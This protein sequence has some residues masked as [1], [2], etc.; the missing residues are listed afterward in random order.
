[1]TMRINVIIQENIENSV[2][3]GSG[4]TSGIITDVERR[5]FNL[6]DTQL[7]RACGLLVGK[8]PTDAFLRSPTPW[9]DLFVTYN[10]AQTQR[11]TSVRTARF[12]GHN[13]VPELVS[14][15]ELVNNSSIGA[16]FNAN[17][18]TT[19]SN[20]VSS[21]WSSSHSISV[22]QEI[23]YKILGIG[24][25]TSFDYTHEWGVGGEQ[26]QTI[27]LS[28]GA[29]VEVYLEPGQAVSAQMVASRGNAQ[30][31]IEYLSYLTGG[32]AMNYYPRYDGHHFRWRAISRIMDVGGISNQ[33]ITRENLNISVYSS[34]RLELIDIKTKKLLRTYYL[35]DILSVGEANAQDD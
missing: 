15:K 24:G 26:S 19:V 25:S 13:A 10:W 34:A 21:S 6:E 27:E 1:M 29:G 30:V 12:V 11:N 2:V 20:T 33:V 8:E 35:G 3:N 17:L 23:E 14:E 16:T 4:I 5:T 31:A 28:T 22:G 32:A 9:N 18:S 7:K